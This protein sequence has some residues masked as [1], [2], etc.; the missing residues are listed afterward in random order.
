[1]SKIK[2]MSFNLR[3]DCEADGINKFSNRFPRVLETI[4]KES[5]DVVG[6]QEVTDPMRDM[7]RKSLPDYCMVG[8]GRGKNLD[9]EA[10]LIGFRA[11][12]VELLSCENYWLSLTP[13]IPGSRYGGDQSGCPRMYTSLLL[14]HKDVEKPF[15]FINHFRNRISFF[16]NSGI[17]HA[18]I[19]RH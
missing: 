14:K 2:I 1:M 9:G 13:T 6:F 3:Y 4:S 17:K 7:L 10:M 5:P 16:Y 11:D 19:N 8:C 15:R 18:A 12:K